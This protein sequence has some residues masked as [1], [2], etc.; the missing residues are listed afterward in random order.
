MTISGLKIEDITIGSGKEVKNGDTVSVHY[1]GT[2][3]DGTVF[4]SSY[5]QNS[6]F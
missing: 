3:L 2:L 1:T 4:D 5:R 6:P